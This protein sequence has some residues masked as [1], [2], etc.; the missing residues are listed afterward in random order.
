MLSQ[1]QSFLNFFLLDALN[2]QA[3]EGHGHGFGRY[4]QGA[5]PLLAPLLAHQIVGVGPVGGIG[6][7]AGD[8]DHRSTLVSNNLKKQEKFNF[9]E[10]LVKSSILLPYL[11]FR[12]LFRGR[13]ELMRKRSN[14]HACLKSTYG[15]SSVYFGAKVLIASLRV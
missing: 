10:I 13:F 9:Q 12:K 8:H 6:R 1:S 7:N 2:S 14:N 5:H 4:F 11:H 15:E 3:L